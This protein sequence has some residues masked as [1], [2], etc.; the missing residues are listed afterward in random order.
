MA[1]L[2][3]PPD[4]LDKN[5][6]LAS[7]LQPGLR[8]DV[9]SSVN[10]AIL[11]SQGRRREARIKDLV[12]LR[13]WA[14]KERREGAAKG[15]LP[16]KI[17]LGLDDGQDAR[18]EGMRDAADGEEREDGEEDE[19]DDEEQHGNGETSDLMVH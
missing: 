18:D 16:A 17:S 9:A 15:A 7:L 1:L 3:F 10:E 2:I 13:A 19:E 4:S 12:R 14:E 5:P 11:E 6:Q 8:K